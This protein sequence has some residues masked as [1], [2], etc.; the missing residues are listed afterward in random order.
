[1]MDPE[2]CIEINHH[3]YHDIGVFNHAQYE[4]YLKMNG[5]ALFGTLTYEE[6]QLAFELLLE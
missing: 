1:M 6:V 5:G 4:A 3:K 2:Y